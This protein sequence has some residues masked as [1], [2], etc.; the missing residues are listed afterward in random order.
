MA[1]Q[2][3]FDSN[4]TRYYCR[5]V[6]NTGI[7][8]LYYN[9]SPIDSGVNA[10]VISSTNTF[11]FSINVSSILFDYLTITDMVLEF[12]TGSY[13][14]DPVLT[15]CSETSLTSSQN[16]ELVKFNKNGNVYSVNL[17]PY[18]NFGIT[19][20]FSI[21]SNTNI[22][23]FNQYNT[24]DYK[25]IL[26]I[27]GIWQNSTNT[28]TVGN[29]CFKVYVPSGLLLHQQ[30][31][32]S[33]DDYT[34]L[35]LNLFY[36]MK[37]YNTNNIHG[38]SNGFPYGFRTSFHQYVYQDDEYYVYLDSNCLRHIFG[39]TRDNDIYY[40]IYGTGLVLYILNNGY[41]IEDGYNNEMLFNSYG[42][43]VTVS[44]SGHTINITLNNHKITKISN[45]TG[46]EININYSTSYIN[47]VFNN[48]VKAKINKS[49]NVLNT[50]EQGS[51]I[52][53]YYYNGNKLTS[54]TSPNDLYYQIVSDNTRRVSQLIVKDTNVSTNIS[55]YDFSYKHKN[56][57]VK[58]IFNV[59]T[60]Y[61]FDEN[62]KFVTEFERISDKSKDVKTIR[63]AGLNSYQSDLKEDELHNTYKYNN[64]EIITLN[65]SS[66]TYNRILTSSN[67]LSLVPGKQYV[68]QY[69][70]ICENVSLINENNFPYI[71]VDNNVDYL[72]QELNISHDTLFVNTI[73][74]KA[75]NN[76]ITVTLHSTI[77]NGT[78]YVGSVRLYEVN[79]YS[80]AYIDKNTG[81]DSV[82]INGNTYYLLAGSITAKYNNT[83]ETFNMTMNDL[84]QNQLNMK[85]GLNYFWYNDLKNIIVNVNSLALII[86]NTE[87][88]I[89]SL[90][91]GV[92]VNDNKTN[93]I[94]FSYRDYN[95]TN[96][97]YK[98]YNIR[99]GSSTLVSTTTY[100]TY[101]NPINKYDEYGVSRDY[102][103]NSNQCLTQDKI[104]KN[105]T[106]ITQDYTYDTT[107]NKT[108]EKEISHIGSNNCETIY[109]YDS[110]G[111][112][113]K[114]TNP[115][116]QDINYTYDNNDNVLSIDSSVDNVLN[117]NEIEYNYEL[118]SKLKH[119]SFNYNFEYDT[120]NL[121]NKIK[122]N[123]NT[124]IEYTNDIQNRIT[125]IKYAT[126][127]YIKQEYDKYGRILYV[128]DSTN[129]SSYTLRLTYVYS[130]NVNQSS[131]DTADTNNSGSKLRR[132]LIGYNNRVFSY[133][134]LNRV[135][136]ISNTS[137]YYSNTENTYD[138]CNRI[139]TINDYKNTLSLLQTIQYKSNVDNRIN[140]ISNAIQYQYNNT[141]K[142]YYYYKTYSYN[143]TLNR[144]DNDILN[145]SNYVLKSEYQYVSNCNLISSV[146]YKTGYQTNPTTN[147]GTIS[148]SYDELGNIT[149]ISDT[150]TNFSNTINFEYDGL[151][152][153]TRENNLKL[154]KSIEYI[155][156][157]GGN[158][159]EKKIGNYTTGPL[160]PTTT[161][162]YGYN[163]T[164]KDRLISYNGVSIS[165]DSMGN[166]VSFLGRTH[167]WT[168]GR[169]LNSVT[170]SDGTL[171][172]SY[173]NEGRRALKYYSSTNNYHT[174]I[175]DNNG[176]I[177]SESIT[178]DSTTNTLNYVYMNGELIGFTYKG[179]AYRYQKNIMGDIIGILDSSSS[180][181]AKYVYDAWGNVTVYDSTGSINTSN[182]FTGNVNPFRFRS[183]YYDR[184]TGYY[185]LKTRY[186]VPEVCRF[187]NLDQIEYLDPKEINGLNLYAYCLNNPVMGYDP[188]GTFGFIG[189]LVVSIII[190]SVI[191]GA[192]AYMKARESGESGVDLFA[193][194]V[195]GALF[196]AA[197]GATV[198]L[199]GAAGLAATGAS[200]TGFGL[201]T[202]AAFGI[203]VGITSTASMAKYSLE[204]VDSKN[205]W[206]L[207]GFVLSGLEGGL[208]GAATFGLA[209]V[210]G[211][212]GLFN[213]FGNFSTPDVFFTKYGGM[214]AL[215]SV[216]WGS[217]LLIG[218]SL[219]RTVFVSG[220][221]M[222]ARRMI[223]LMI[224]DVFGKD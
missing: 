5:G 91:I 124:L 72:Y 73:Y 64:N 177:I 172:F 23:L 47:F 195:G 79:L 169:L 22:T 31:L 58:D 127:Y 151:G 110:S 179:N 60:I 99:K 117:K 130:D 118:I 158:I 19:N 201:S 36:D 192:T 74:I 145:L 69:A 26:K 70:Y 184:E 108:L 182:T 164:I 188:E 149:N 119:N 82:I 78:I 62:G 218:E 34:P 87:Y 205:K 142:N 103:Y 55:K 137:N 203:S 2:K 160:S 121:V 97:L 53:H 167:T 209:F 17:A 175:Y 185:Y 67:T 30:N 25:P 98:E 40:D 63:K 50:L 111:R 222:L 206:N 112:V 154:N 94:S 52:S 202:G 163:T 189:S 6:N 116:S 11:N 168:K 21:H 223:D 14:T 213:K 95:M 165:Y 100:N 66:T 150:T 211:R 12:I 128:S 10:N 152:R 171:Y 80:G 104:S 193:S 35:E 198:V 65:G 215:R 196:G 146:T 29:D 9:H 123:T 85:K 174:Y 41:K 77:K 48:V 157:S 141:T 44:N 194:T 15:L 181:I 204:C 207:G 224:P 114:I 176:N 133:D 214:N 46:K 122:Q 37:Y 155:Y 143:G 129:G 147:F 120:F 132:I 49:S 162:N 7:T 45:D 191:G 212:A 86:N 159:T 197:I 173:D 54:F 178:N 42:E 71:T 92:L 93:V 101:V 109:Q 38:Y 219:S 39:A 27:F 57:I 156:D 216:V 105:G 59:S 51:N 140:K 144:I 161:I 96:N 136:G 8:N 33:V 56:T 68:L 3:E 115:L 90:K 18:C 61:E 190:G 139:Y 4:K 187:I 75:N 81:L 89:T 43:L 148:Y 166:P 88:N 221:S 186:Y 84:Y 76:P 220:L 200:V 16:E 131:V 20:Y 135:T 134:N 210:G 13:P 183:Y 113:T 138:N 28:T 102:F 180:L 208:Q 107:T 1:V 125:I 217:K 199:G 153:L 106:I 170:T 32:V 126:N 24:D 83:I